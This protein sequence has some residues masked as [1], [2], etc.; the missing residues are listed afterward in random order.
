MKRSPHRGASS[1]SPL[2]RARQR[3]C[4]R[5]SPDLL[6][7]I[8][9]LLARGGDVLLFREQELYTMTEFVNRYTKE[10]VRFVVG[11]SLLI[12]VWNPKRFFSRGGTGSFLASFCRET[13]NLLT[14]Q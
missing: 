11:L 2:F 10:P 12:R 4:L 5:R 7:R 6:N 8:D 1:A 3:T 14:E 13:R 9:A